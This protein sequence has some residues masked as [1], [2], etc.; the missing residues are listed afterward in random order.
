MGKTAASG[1]ARREPARRGTLRD[2]QRRMTRRRLADAALELFEEV[3]YADTTAEAIAR[4]AG[5][6]RATFYLHYASKADVVLELMERVRGEVTEMFATA[7]ALE[8]PT[9]A[10]V[11]SWL[12]DVLAFWDRNRALIDANHQAMPVEEHVAQQWWRGFEE[13][14]AA[15]PLANQPGVAGE[16]E[17]VRVIT[18]L[19]GF[20]Q[21]CW[22]HVLRG[23]P[24]DRARLLDGLTEDWH[25]LL[26]RVA[27][28]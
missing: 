11:R 7:W 21:V 26:N 25:A 16:R 18:A 20:E 5:A 22:F 23:A 27:D 4:R 10:E 3:G 12:E 9:K 24:I 1:R 14:A 13:V 28:R 19:A 15:S 8:Q 2:E 17:R 6:T